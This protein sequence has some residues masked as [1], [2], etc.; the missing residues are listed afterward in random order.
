MITGQC[1]FPA[2]DKLYAF[3]AGHLGPEEEALLVQH[4]EGCSNCEQR[5]HLVDRESEVAGAVLRQPSG[6]ATWGDWPSRSLQ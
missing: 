4:L 3:L 5:L 1:P 6:E 2:F